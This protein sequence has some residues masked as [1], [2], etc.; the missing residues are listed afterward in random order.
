MKIINC[1][2]T[3]NFNSLLPVGSFLKT[4][5]GDT[6]GTKGDWRVCTM[7]YLCRVIQTNRMANIKPLFF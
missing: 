7:L 1:I 5:K 2:T 3:L 6:M 4:N